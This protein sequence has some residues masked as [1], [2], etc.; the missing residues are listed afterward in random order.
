M[1]PTRIKDLDALEKE[2][3]D[4]I[5]KNLSLERKDLN[6]GDAAWIMSLYGD[7]KRARKLFKKAIDKGSKDAFVH[8]G[9]AEIRYYK[10]RKVALKHAKLAVEYDPLHA[11]AW[12]LQGRCVLDED[13][14]EGLRLLKLAR[15]IAPD[16]RRIWFWAESAALSDD[17]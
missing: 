9:Y 1:A 3:Y 16:D 17:E 5:K 2:W 11:R 10:K 15:E 7:N 8:Y 13:R 4:Y 12:A 14:E 6:Y